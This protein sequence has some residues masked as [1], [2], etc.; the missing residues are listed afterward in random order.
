MPVRSLFSVITV[1]L[2]FSLSAQI[3]DDSTKQVYGPKTTK[4]ITELEIL[5]NDGDYQTLDT[6]I[7]LFERQSVVDKSARTLQNLGV[8]G[9]AQFPIFHTPAELI[10]RSSGFSA[11]SRF[12]FRPEDIRFYDTK[13]PFLE[14]FGLLGGGNRNIID[15]GFSRNVDKRWNIGFDYKVHTVDKQLARDGQGDRQVESAAFAAYTHYKHEKIPYQIMFQYTQLNH[16]TVELG[17][18]R[19]F[20]SENRR[21]DLFQF[22]TALLRLEDA[23][24]NVKDRRIH[25][26]QDYQLAE[27]FQI[28][29]ILDRHTEQ[30]SFEDFAGTSSSTYNSYT[31]FYTNFFIDEDSTYQRANFTELSNEAGIKGDISSVFYRAYLKFRWVDFSYNFLDPTGRAFEQFVGGYARFKWRDK[32]SIVA[33]GQYILGGGYDFKGTL[34]SNLINLY[35]RTSNYAVPYVYN[36]YFGNHH[37]WSNSFD[38]T[39]TNTLGGNIRARFKFLEVVPEVNV[40]SYQNYLYFDQDRQP[41]QN[42]GTFLMTRLGGHV[43]L[44]FLNAK[45]EGWHLENQIYYTNVAGDGAAQVRVPELFYNG[46]IFWRGNW[47]SDLVPFEVGLDTHA[48]SAYFANNF[49]PETQQF[50]LQDEY[51]LEGFYTANLF[52]NMRLDKFFLSVKWTHI[53]QPNDGGYLASPFYPGQPRALDVNVRWMFFD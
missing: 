16:N 23:Q 29:N 6:S 18:A 48:R 21:T 4:F 3:V 45:E 28:Y 24:T 34:S 33:D 15:I 5:N 35:Y 47:F 43:N 38:P 2:V 37:E 25:I 17:G 22:E 40:T 39:F 26:Y 41:V 8:I 7:Y 20:T 44:R 32:F 14:L 13:S 50:Y 1:F 36:N 19:F 31:D 49:A 12:A 30:H 52:I 51:E 46:R 53:D 9:T 42:T 11:Y 10:G 27:Q